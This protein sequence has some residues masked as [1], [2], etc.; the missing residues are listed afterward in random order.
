ME[1][2]VHVC[3][4]IPLTLEDLSLD[5]TGYH[6]YCYKSFTGKI[7]LLQ[8]SQ[9]HV[10]SLSVQSEGAPRRCSF[11]FPNQCIFCDK[12]KSEFKGKTEKL[13]KFQSWKHKEPAWKVIEPR[14]Q[15]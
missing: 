9:R 1:T 5:T 3:E 11:L 4:Q 6:Q 12:A 13:T 8:V 15:E 2:S 7:D 10:K 14:A